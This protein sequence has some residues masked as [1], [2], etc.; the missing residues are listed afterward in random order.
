MSA[1]IVNPI[2]FDDPE[3]VLTDVGAWL[4]GAEF[5]IHPVQLLREELFQQQ[6]AALDLY[7]LRFLEMVMAYCAGP[8]DDVPSHVIRDTLYREF[9]AA[10]VS[11]TSVMDQRCGRAEANLTRLGFIVPKPSGI[12]VARQ[13]WSLILDELGDCG[14]R[15]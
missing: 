2:E 4:V 9:R 5:E 7:D 3:T 13:W 10:G 15:T 6:F 12:T 14:R 1:A 8:D 11:D